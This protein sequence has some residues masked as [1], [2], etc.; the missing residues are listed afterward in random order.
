MYSIRATLEPLMRFARSVE[1]L[2]DKA[3]SDTAKATLRRLRRGTYWKN[4]T[5]ALAKSFNIERKGLAFY[6]VASSSP[7][8][9]FLDKGTRAHTIEAKNARALRFRANG[10]IRFAKRVHHPGTKAIYF[11]A[12]EQVVGSAALAA[13]AE[14][15]IQRAAAG[16]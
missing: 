2:S 6:V 16:A 7:V 13:A 14:D 1:K 10:S 5:G 8:A 15:A 3:A 4:R 9:A 12:M 11:E